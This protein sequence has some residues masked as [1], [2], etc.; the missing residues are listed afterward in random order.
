MAIGLF[1]ALALATYYSV[2]YAISGDPPTVIYID[3]AT[4]AP[5]DQASARGWP[6]PEHDDASASPYA[7]PDRRPERLAWPPAASPKS[8]PDHPIHHQT[9]RPPDAGAQT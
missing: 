1:G 5:I 4:G 2:R 6:Q 3:Q 7:R 8:S 9:F